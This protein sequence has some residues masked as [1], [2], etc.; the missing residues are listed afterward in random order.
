MQR[1]NKIK[2]DELMNIFSSMYT[3]QDRAKF[4]LLWQSFYKTLSETDKKM[5][6]NAWFA[7]MLDNAKKFKEE[8]MDFAENGSLEDRQFVTEMFN[9]IKEH[10][11]MARET[12]GAS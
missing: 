10:P 6:L 5:A 4:Q 11:F 7:N 3:D 1:E 8:S 12:S 9:S 2:L